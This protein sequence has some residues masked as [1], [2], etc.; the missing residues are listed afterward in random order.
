LGVF[1]CPVEG[2][3]MIVGIYIVTGIYGNAFWDTG[4]L[5]FAG[6]DRLDSL[7]KIIPN[8]PLNE[9]FMVFGGV[10]L[11]F[12][13]FTS[14]TNVYRSRLAAGK[15]PHTPLLYLLPFPVTVALQILWLS[16]PSFAHSSIVHSSLFVPF[17]CAWGLQFAHQVG[18]MILAHI[19]STP[20]PWWNWLW[21]FSLVGALDANAPQF[22]GRAPYI[23]S[24]PA[25]TGIFVYLVLAVSFVTYAQFCTA[26]INEITN[27]LGIACFTVRKKDANGVWRTAQAVDGKKRS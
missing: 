10:G 25:T 11:M 3:L 7:T 19:T 16:A 23:Q 26:V 6:L 13:I 27:Y 21:V 17:L 5:T 20:L 2:I 15:S 4:I 8:V 18:R 12:N 9:V 22:F 1:S 24:T 14:Y